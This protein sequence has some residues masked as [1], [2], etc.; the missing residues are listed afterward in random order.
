MLLNN[1]SEDEEDSDCI[2]N[3]QAIHEAEGVT[4][5][6]SSSSDEEYEEEHIETKEVGGK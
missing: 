6:S 4:T 3:W 2:S 1:I 5:S